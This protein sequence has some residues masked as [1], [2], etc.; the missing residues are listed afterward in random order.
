M[1]RLEMSLFSEFRELLSFNAMANLSLLNGTLNKSIQKR[2]Y[3][4]CLS[5]GIMADTTFF[6]SR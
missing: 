5:W 2:I 6:T 3:Y 4:A 1:Q